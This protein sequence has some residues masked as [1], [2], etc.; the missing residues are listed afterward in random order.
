MAKKFLIF[1]G[2]SLFFFVLF[3]IFFF[4]Q[5][6]FNKKIQDL[7]E[8]SKAQVSQIKE[9]DAK[10]ESLEK[11]ISDL[12]KE[13]IKMKNKSYSESESEEV[14]GS[15]ITEKLEK[16][17]WCQKLENQKPKRE[18]IFNEICWM[19]DKDSSSNEWIELKNISGKDLDLTGWQLK[20]K[21]EKI[22]IVL[23]GKVK[24]RWIFYFREGRGSSSRN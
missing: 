4:A 6:S 15:E 19:G 8:Y 16:E 14:A 9:K 1:G 18:V 17:K 21:D 20:N 11:E 22:K 12:K 13:I 24:K 3:S 10:I 7:L 2:I 23:E 5:N